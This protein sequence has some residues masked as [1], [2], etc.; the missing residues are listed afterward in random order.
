MSA[1]SAKRIVGANGKVDV[2]LIGIG[3]RGL[4]NAKM[5]DKTGLANVVAICDVNLGAPHTQEVM[6]MFP[7]ARQ[8]QDWR[9]MFDE[10]HSQI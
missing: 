1:A 7:A 4:E 10:M 8:Y 5:V 9:K 3:H 6:G 2:A